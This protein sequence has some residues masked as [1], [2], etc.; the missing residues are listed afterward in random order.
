MNA[1]KNA[2]NFG[3]EEMEALQKSITETRFRPS[4]NPLVAGLEQAS[5]V[6]ITENTAKAY[7][8]TLNYLLDFF[9]NAGALRKRSDDDIVGYFSKA[10]AQDKLLA[11]KALFY[12]RDVR[13]GQGERKTFRV[14]LKWLANNYPDVF[15]KNIKNI[16][17]YGRFDDLYCV[18]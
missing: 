12:I 18:F 15:I 13:G 7:K 4:I 1:I 16:P 9:G 6:T 11:L 14:I 5:N 2:N 17:D 3:Y 8:S 10:F